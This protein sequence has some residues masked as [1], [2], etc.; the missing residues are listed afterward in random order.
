MQLLSPFSPLWYAAAALVALAIAY[1]F[2]FF[3]P[4]KSYPNPWTQRGLFLLKALSTFLILFLF[5]NPILRKNNRV[6][7]KPIIGILVDQSQS[8]ALQPKGST[9]IQ[10]IPQKIEKIQKKL[11]QLS[12]KHLELEKN[13]QQ[14]VKSYKER[15][16]A[17]DQKIKDYE[18]QKSLQQRIF[19]QPPLQPDPE[20]LVDPE[21]SPDP[22][23]QAVKEEIARLERDKENYFKILQVRQQKHI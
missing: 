9:V 16:Q 8:I 18:R 12:Q 10:E 20:L 6:V 22:E 5:I 3:K 7:Q 17:F 4:Q 13:H 14:R 1:L 19:G 23:L 21:L 2:Y 11:E 15:V